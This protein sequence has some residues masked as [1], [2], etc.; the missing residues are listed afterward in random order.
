MNV[1][2]YCR[3][4]PLGH[5]LRGE[6]HRD[7]RR[8]PAQRGR[9]ARRNPQADETPARKAGVR[10]RRRLRRRQEHRLEKLEVVVDTRETRLESASDVAG[11]ARHPREGLHQ[12][13]ELVQ[14]LRKFARPLKIISLF[15]VQPSVQG[16]NTC[17]GYIA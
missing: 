2:F 9:A 6:V 5:Q 13:K 15:N 1:L 11:G 17:P 8:H 12:L 7:V 14:V 10:R 4:S 16:G 3:G